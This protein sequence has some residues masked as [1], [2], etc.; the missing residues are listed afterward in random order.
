MAIVKPTPAQLAEQ[1]ELKSCLRDLEQPPILYSLNV[2]KK[3]GIPAGL[4]YSYL[5]AKQIEQ[6]AYREEFNMRLGRR[7]IPS[8]SHD[9]IFR[10]LNCF[11]SVTTVK[12]AA[13]EL[14]DAELITTENSGAFLEPDHQTGRKRDLATWW[15]VFNTKDKGTLSISRKEVADHGIAAALLLALCRSLPV[16]DDGYWKVSAVEIAKILP[17]DERTVRRHI[18]ALVKE[19]TLISHSQKAKLYRI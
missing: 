16:V 11:E 8:L 5:Q 7:W 6:T 4:L 3:H 14:T 2:G 12:N 13:A 19:G 17:M 9:Q 15:H 18:K 10:D 1:D